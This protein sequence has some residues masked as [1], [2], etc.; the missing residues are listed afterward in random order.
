VQYLRYAVEILAA[1]AEE[2]A[3]ERAAVRLG[4]PVRSLYRHIDQL[5][6]GELCASEGQSAIWPRSRRQPKRDPQPG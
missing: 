2:G 3:V 1:L 5:G 6:L 4:V